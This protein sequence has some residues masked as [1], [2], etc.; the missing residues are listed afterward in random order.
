MAVR[1]RPR[2]PQLR[3]VLRGFCLG[4][5]VFLGRALEEGDELPFAFDEHPQRAGPALYQYRPLVQAF[6]ESRAAALADRDDAR[7]ALDALLR[8]PA[9]AVY[10]SAHAGLRPSEDQALL[11]TVLIPL[12]VSTAEACG[13]FDWDDDA[14]ERGYAE[15]ERS[16]YG[17]SRAYAAVAPLVGLSVVTQVELGDGVRI[18]PVAA[19]ELTLHWPEAQ[20]LLPAG[21][22]AEVDRYCVLELQRAL[23]LGEEAPDAPAELADVVSA[24]RLAT[25]APVCAGPV[26]FERLDWRPF[27]IRPLLAISAAQPAG[28][29]TRLDAFRAELVRELS[30]RLARADD[31]VALA[32][33]L[34]RW[35]ISLFELGPVR[36]EQLRGVL[37]ALFG[38]AFELRVAVLLGRDAD[39][40]RRLHESLRGLGAGGAAVAATADVVRRALVATLQRGEREELVR[41]LDAMLLG[42]G[43]GGAVAAERPAAALTA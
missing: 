16:L 3:L 42:G 34:D 40:R 30:T 28:E 11:R 18:R 25:A 39:E 35:E 5:F 12:L 37:V 8:E 19:G 33:A 38:D 27:G 17:V 22:G 15:L 13:G 21:F 20:S 14:F 7:L 26:V 24:L 9:A 32:E 43:V 41:E 29:P 4:A 1:S 36:A 2:A 31:D 10:A 6:I 23:E